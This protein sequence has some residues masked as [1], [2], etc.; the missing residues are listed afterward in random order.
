MSCGLCK[1]HSCSSG[2]WRSLGCNS[3]ELSVYVSGDLQFRIKPG[4]FIVLS[5][6]QMAFPT[7]WLCSKEPSLRESSQMQNW[8]L[9]LPFGKVREMNISLPQAFECFVKI[10]KIYGILLK[11]WF[12]TKKVLFFHIIIQSRLDLFLLP[13]N[14]LEFLPL[15]SVHTGPDSPGC[16]GVWNTFVSVKTSWSGDFIWDRKHIF[17]LHFYFNLLI[18]YGK[19]PK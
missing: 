12:F 14:L 5:A 17:Q 15:N 11:Q 2:S 16:F 8:E 13:G 18:C 10:S 3:V 6:L 19:V 4:Y 1:P 7:L 9:F